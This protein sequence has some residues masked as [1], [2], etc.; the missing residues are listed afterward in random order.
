ML[1]REATKSIAS[2]NGRFQ[3]IESLKPSLIVPSS[4]ATFNYRTRIPSIRFMWDEA[5]QATSYKVEIANNPNMENPI[6]EQ[7]TNLTSVIISTLENGTYWW[8]VTPFY[9]I[10]NVGFSNPSEVQSFTIEKKDVLKEPTLFMPQQNGLVNTAGTISFSWKQESEAESYI[11]KIANN[12]ELKNPYINVVTKD[13]YFTI[14]NTNNIQSLKDGKWYWSVAV[15]DFEGNISDFSKIRTF[16][17]LKGKPEQHLIEPLDG[18]KTGDGFVFDTKFTWK[19]NLPESFESYIQFAKDRNFTQIEKEEKVIGSSFDG[20]NLKK[21]TYYWRLKSV[22]TIDGAE[23]VTGAREFNVVGNLEA[24]TL[25]T[26][27]DKAIARENA[28]YKFSWSEVSEASYY[29]I[30]I[31]EKAENKLV[32]DDVVYGTEFNVDLYH[33]KDFKDKTMYRW[34]VQAHANAIPGISSRRTGKIAEGN[35][36]FAR[37]RPVSIDFPPQNYVLKGED[38]ILK[39]ITAKWSSVDSVKS[40]QFVL[41]KIEGKTIKEIIK[42]PSDLQMKNN[43]LVAK[44]SILLDTKDGLQPGKYEIIVYAKTYDD[45]DISNTDANNIR[46][47]TVLPIEPLEQAKNLQVTPESFDI[48]YLKIKE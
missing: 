19:R 6:V 17:T 9:I 32:F 7:R 46:K 12:E 25:L 36:Y 2:Q 21:G 26:P 27:K 41:R 30:M 48:N 40:A 35:F 47:F 33:N 18:F 31:Y 44:N 22:N 38:A 1:H 28:P 4:K 37:L 5:N 14:K 3:I 20:I 29:K 45:I 42:T 13:N 39:P 16:F 8:R 34:E 43:V 10:N 23:I 15:Q 24:A 11:I